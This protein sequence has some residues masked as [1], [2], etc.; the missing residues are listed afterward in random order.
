MLYEAIN[1]SVL[2][3]V[4]TVAKRIL[5]LGCGSGVLGREIKR[6]IGCEVTGITFSDEE[7]TTAKEWL[8]NVI[9][10]DLNQFESCEL[11]SFDTIICS[12]ILE[13]LYHPQ[14]LLA[15]LRD[16]LSPDGILI[17]ALPNIL[18]WKQRSEFLRG[19]FRYTDGGIMDQTHYRFFDWDS[20]YKLVLG[21]KFEIISR[22][23]EGHFPLPV[24]REYLQPVAHYIDKYAT[25]IA[26]GLFGTQ[27]IIVAR[28]GAE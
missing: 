17:V 20:S 27:F 3:V 19:Q 8:D 9:V 25:K 26:P 11:G 4:P 28:R 14:E 12:H 10:C 23:A 16:N 15:Q 24:I 18:H 21:A 5:D 7:A 1:Q 22:T 6:K 13:H 2:S